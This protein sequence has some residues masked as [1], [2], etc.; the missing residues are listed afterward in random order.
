MQ[1][2]VNVVNGLGGINDKNRTIRRKCYSIVG[3]CAGL[4]V[5]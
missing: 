2:V 4:L 3:R 5:L 1:S